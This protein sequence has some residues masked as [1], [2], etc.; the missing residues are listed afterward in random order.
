MLEFI[1][2][3]VG[4]PLGFGL[5]FFAY[6]L[7][8]SQVA[9]Q[10]SDRAQVPTSEAFYICSTKFVKDRPLVIKSINGVGKTIKMEWTAQDNYTIEKI[11]DVTYIAYARREENG[12]DQIVL[13]RVTGELNFADHPSASVKDLLTDL[14]SQR[15]PWSECEKRIPS[16]KGGRPTECSFVINQFSCPRLNNLG[17]ISE[18]Q[19]QCVPTERR[20]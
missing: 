6:P 17:V 18:A 3:I 10:K 8:E 19:F 11:D 14:C 20:F 13:N 5:A 1:G 16:M 12:S 15:I 2:L 4:L 7:W 9:I